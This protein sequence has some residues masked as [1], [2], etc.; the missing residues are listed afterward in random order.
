[1]NELPE[2]RIVPILIPGLGRSGTTA[3]MALLGSDPRVAFDREYPYEHRYLTYFLTFALFFERREL[4][5]FSDPNQLWRYD[6]LGLG[7]I[8]PAVASRGEAPEAYLPVPGTREWLRACWSAF[9][10]N[11]SRHRPETAFYAEKTPVWVG[12]IVREELACRVLYLFRD[13][14]DVYLSANAFIRKRNRFG[15]GRSEADS[16]AAHARR[17]TL[18]FLHQFENYRADRDR[19]DTTLLRYEDL[20]LDRRA[21]SAELERTLGVRP[22]PECGFEDFEM[23]RTVRNL[24]D[25]VRRWTRERL[26]SD[27]ARFFATHAAGELGELGYEI[28]ARNTN[29]AGTVHFSYAAEPHFE[30]SRDG[31]LELLPDCARVRIT[32]PDFWMILPFD[33]FDAG[34]AA[35]LWACVQGG[36]GWVNSVYWRP[37]NADFSEERSIHLP[38]RPARHW[39]IA[40]FELRS[41]PLWKGRIA[42]LRLD[43][44]NGAGH[45]LEGSGL[46]RWVRLVK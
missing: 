11:L 17:L 14:R 44:F 15:F 20:A 22:N 33:R 16:D 9:A 25:T 37:P 46:L 5:R 10:G 35:E 19:S 27:A 18:E 40:R 28:D 43:I 21:F 41:H 13:L 1:M 12:P 24:A 45:R 30:Q 7:L 34:D 36:A 8:A 2:S 42:A 4:L 23:H 32:G 39:Q 38:F 3:L 6:A 26:P 31:S 29:R